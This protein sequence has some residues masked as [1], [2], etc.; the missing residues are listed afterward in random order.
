MRDAIQSLQQHHQIVGE[1]GFDERPPQDV[2]HRIGLTRTAYDIIA[3]TSL[4][5][6]MRIGLHA[7]FNDRMCEMLRFMASDARYVG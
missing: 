1:R 3:G 7:G 6:W 2:A 4:A 5:G